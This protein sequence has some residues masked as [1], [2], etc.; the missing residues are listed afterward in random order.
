MGEPV[1]AAVRRAA[2]EAE[3]EEVDDD[4]EEVIDAAHAVH[5][6]SGPYS[7]P[8]ADPNDHDRVAG[9]RDGQS[10]P[11]P[12]LR[13]LDTALEHISTAPPESSNPA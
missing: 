12:D 5:Q 3:V 6:G 9:Y 1:E 11:C 8:P 4:D 2:A 13:P 10:A 7:T